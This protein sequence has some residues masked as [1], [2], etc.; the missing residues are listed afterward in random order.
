MASSNFDIV[1]MRAK[2]EDGKAFPRRAKSRDRMPLT[3]VSFL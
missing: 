2:A 1:G 3:T